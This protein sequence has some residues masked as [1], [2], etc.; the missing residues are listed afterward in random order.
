MLAAETGYGVWN[1]V[2]MCYNVLIEGHWPGQWTLHCNQGHHWTMSNFRQ[3]S[4]V[5][6][7]ITTDPYPV[8]PAWKSVVTM[9]YLKVT[10]GGSCFS[11]IVCLPLFLMSVTFLHFHRHYSATNRMEFLSIFHGQGHGS[12]PSDCFT[13]DKHCSPTRKDTRSLLL[14]AKQKQKKNSFW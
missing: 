13:E 1:C 6:T 5:C 10:S 8:W 4:R 7:D 9:S 12:H 14:K 3:A 11:A 2:P